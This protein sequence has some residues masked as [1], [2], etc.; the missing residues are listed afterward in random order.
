MYFIALFDSIE[1]ARWRKAYRHKIEMREKKGSNFG[2]LF[3]RFYMPTVLGLLISSF[4]WGEHRM[5]L[6]SI[7]SSNICVAKTEINTKIVNHQ[8]TKKKERKRFLSRMIST[9]IRLINCSFGNKLLTFYH[10]QGAFLPLIKNK[11]KTKKTC[12]Q[13]PLKCIWVKSLDGQKQ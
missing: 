8:M 13:I 3:P 2:C 11:Q 9:S 5:L 12:F 4:G 6:L 7:L 10:E 1:I